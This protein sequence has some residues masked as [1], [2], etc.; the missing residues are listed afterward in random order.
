[1]LDLLV[2]RLTF[3]KQ[4]PNQSKKLKIIKNC[5]TLKSVLWLQYENIIPNTKL[6]L[7]IN[8]SLQKH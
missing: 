8:I 2:T 5:I 6:A 3:A 1:M 7:Y 4:K